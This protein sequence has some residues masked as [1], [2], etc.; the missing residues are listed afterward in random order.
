MLGINTYLGDANL[1]IDRQ[2]NSNRACLWT[3]LPA[4]VQNVNL[5]A[6]TVDAQPAIKGKQEL[7]DG[8][9]RLVNLPLLLD[10]P[11]VFPHGG[12]C[13]LTFPVKPGDE[14]LI[15][16]ASRGIDFWWQSGGIQPPAEVRMHDLSDGFALMGTYSQPKRLA[17]VS[18]G[19]VQLR[20]D[21][22]QAYFELNPNSHAFTLSTPSDFSANV[23]AFKVTASTVTIN[24][25]AFTVNAP[26][27]ALNGQIT[28]GGS[29]GATANF[30]GS[31]NVTKD[32]TAGGISLRNHTHPGDSGGTTGAPK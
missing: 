30:T 10:C 7:E 12:G 13:S 20:S 23:N 27:I 28:G 17:N 25:S 31:V 18:A 29:S 3:A 26:S 16:F 14:C 6:M 1:Q 21:D 2:I 32:V 8:T 4:I 9:V 24:A 22:G 11:L 19:A 15:V 5:T